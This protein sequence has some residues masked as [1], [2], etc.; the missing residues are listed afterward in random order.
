MSATA[1]DGGPGDDRLVLAKD[2]FAAGRSL[3]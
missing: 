1:V 2:V 3:G